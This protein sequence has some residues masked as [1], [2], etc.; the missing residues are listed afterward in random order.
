M[1]LVVW[2][3]DVKERGACGGVYKGAWG[4]EVNGVQKESK[5]EKG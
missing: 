4:A 1:A 3:R 5:R 2:S